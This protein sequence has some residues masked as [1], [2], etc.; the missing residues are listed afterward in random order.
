LQ[1]NVSGFSAFGGPLVIGD[2]S[3]TGS[4]TVRLLQSTEIDNTLPITLNFASLFD[5][6][7]SSDTITPTLTMNGG[8]ITTGTGQLS[9]GDGSPIIVQLGIAS[10]KGKL[11]VGSTT[12]LISNS[13]PLL[14]DAAVSGS[15]TITK[16]GPSH[17]DFGGANTYTGLTIIQQGQ[18]IA[19]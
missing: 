18:L 8:N 3:G 15:A 17:A 14:M 7:N 6:N 4:P 10:I 19:Q 16:I 11:N 9:L 2:G 12:C 1:L 5:L 13:F